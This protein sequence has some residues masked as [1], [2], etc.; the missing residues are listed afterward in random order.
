MSKKSFPL[1]VVQLDLARQM[2]TV[3]FI[4]K[5]IDFAAANRF[6]A[7]ALYLE[8]R[9]KTESFP[10]PADDESYQPEQIRSIVEYARSKGVEVIPVVSTLGHAEL[11]LS[12]SEMEPLMETRTPFTGKFGTTERK[13]FC[14]SQADTYDFLRQYLTE[15]AA[16]FPSKYLHVGCDETWDIGCCDLC[17]A[18]TKNGEHLILLKH[19]QAI[20]RIVSG[21][22]G[23]T[24]IMW[25][26]ML[27]QYPE[28]LP[29]L[30]RDI[31]MACW[32]YQDRVHPPRGHF[33]HCEA[34]DTLGE[35][36]RLGFRYL[37][38][39]ADYTLE[40]AESFT[41]YA[42]EYRPL[43]GWLTLWE[44]RE[45]TPLQSYPLIAA[46]GWLW[47]FDSKSPEVVI[48]DFFGLR[49]PVFS[50]AI[51]AF[52]RSGFYKERYSRPES[53]LTQRENSHNYARE[54]LV[55]LLLKVLPPCRDQI[56]ADAKDVLEEIL[57]SLRS[58]E[59]S[60]RVALLFKEFYE[61]RYASPEKEAA[62]AKII[63]EV[64]CLAS[65]RLA[66]N[67]RIR[68]GLSA[69]NLR[70]LYDEYIDNLRQ[71]SAHAASHGYLKVHFFLP[72]QF[73]AQTTRISIR[74]AGEL[75]AEQVG[76]GIYKEE[77]NFEAYYSRL[78]P[79]DPDKV[80]EEITV[81]TWGYGGQGFTWF[82]A[83][84]T[85]GHHTPSQVCIIQGKLTNPDWLLCQDWRESYAGE[86]DAR[87]TFFDHD[88]A[89]EIHAFRVLLA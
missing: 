68:P 3:D 46:V 86:R 10:Y 15:I 51:T 14:P 33:L 65:E 19:L 2:E 67:R 87:I 74:Y 30:P 28:I 81:E 80:P 16:L 44:K 23:K 22:L 62:L 53:F 34:V 66:F 58:E 1:R 5:F 4:G 49:D 41:A 73:C 18:R 27:F 47:C 72:D 61:Q 78:F 89:Q 55:D 24:M 29:L 45:M 12:Y 82:E 9:I 52:C 79:I 85:T 6:N 69:K 88:K 57:L 76:E 40:N 84:N 7:L 56:A 26:D 25:D 70:A 8:G 60:R 77:R 71:L 43:G 75:Q 39:P 21:E 20:H 50:S 54:G 13:A 31:V 64:E 48:R 59:L 17:A 36:D 37:I 83:V 35:Y 11:F 32:Q 38:C 63:H 42:A